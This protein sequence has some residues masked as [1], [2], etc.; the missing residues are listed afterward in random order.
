MRNAL[1]I[2]EGHWS[3][4]WDRPISFTLLAVVVVSLVL[5]PMWTIIQKKRSAA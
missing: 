5:P 2:G 1:S 3:V 4:F